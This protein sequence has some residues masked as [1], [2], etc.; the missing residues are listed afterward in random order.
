[1]KQ[2]VTDRVNSFEN[3]RNSYKNLYDDYIWIQLNYDPKNANIISLVFEQ[4][5]N[6]TN[7]KIPSKLLSKNSVIINLTDPNSEFYIHNIETLKSILN[8]KLM[9]EITN[10]HYP[11]S[12]WDY[13]LKTRPQNCLTADIDALEITNNG[14]TAIEAAQLFDTSSINNA[15]PH[16]F[17]T[18]NFRKNKV[19]PNQYYAQFRYAGT[20]NA[21]AF[22]LFHKI[23]GTVLDEKSPV[24]LLKN[25]EMFYKLLNF[26]LK[27][28]R[29]QENIFIE[30]CS[31]FLHNSLIQF[32][33]IH[34]A[35][36]YIKSI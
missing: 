15:I 1:M 3:W 22:I 21:E 8:L 32:K 19:N 34:E 5:T 7:L 4:K 33:N 26:I 12:Y 17:R 13:R 24:F 27:L 11:T 20:I 9:N 36:R 2:I 31:P 35:Y 6:Q 30:R 28:D 10:N 14:F 29:S 25:D 16:I 18:F 23:N